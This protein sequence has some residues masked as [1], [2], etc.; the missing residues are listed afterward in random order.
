MLIDYIEWMITKLL[1]KMDFYK[2]SFSDSK[3]L[4]TRIINLWFITNL[5]KKLFWITS[6][7]WKKLFKIVVGLFT[8]MMLNKLFVKKLSCVV[9]FKKQ[10]N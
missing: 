5:I 6:Q 3:T 8:L 1:S 2:K 4:N 7:E 10:N 9:R